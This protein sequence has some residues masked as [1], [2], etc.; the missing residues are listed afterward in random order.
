MLLL[1]AGLAG[2][3]AWMRGSRHS[4]VSGQGTRAVA[5]LGI[6]NAGRH[7]SRS[8]LTAGLLGAAA[9][10]LVGVESFRR[11][12]GKDYLRKEGG[13]GGYNLLAECDT[14]IFLD[15]NT[16]AGR[17]EILNKLETRWN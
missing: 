14:P 3:S 6:R 16:E 13:S 17:E 1:T 7:P 10:L 2:L 4:T 11:E 8:L 9:F 15:L 5:R 12:P